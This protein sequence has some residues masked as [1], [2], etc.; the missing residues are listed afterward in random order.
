MNPFEDI[1][2]FLEDLVKTGAF[3]YWKLLSINIIGVKLTSN[4]G[5]KLRIIQ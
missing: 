4:I 2:L 3:E 5:M 1:H